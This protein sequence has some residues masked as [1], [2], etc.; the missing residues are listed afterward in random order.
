MTTLLLFPVAAAA[1]LG[2]FFLALSQIGFTC[3]KMSDGIL[4]GVTETIVYLAAALLPLYLVWGFLFERWEAFLW[5]PEEGPA[6][7]VLA[8]LAWCGLIT[9]VTYTAIDL[10]R[11]D[12][13]QARF[14][15]VKV[16]T[17]DVSYSSPQRLPFPWSPRWN[18]IHRLKRVH[19]DIRIPDLPEDLRGLRIGHL[20]DFH[21]G[22]ECHEAF[23]R[24]A[25]DRLM[26]TRPD[27]L[28]ITGDFVN[29]SKYLDDSFKVLEGLTA[30]LGVYVVRG[31]HDYWVGPEKV[32]EHV[33]NAGFTLLD[34]VT[35]PVRKGACEFH[36][37]G[38]ESR[39]NRTSAPFDY[40][41]L[42][43]SSLE[44]V[45]S[46]TPDEFPK[47]VGRKPHLVLSGHTHGGQLCLPFYGPIVVPS[48]YGRKY[49]AGLFREGRTLMVVSRGIGCYPPIRLMCDPE[50]H[51]I[52]FV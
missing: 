35:I 5:S 13:R 45:L 14:E 49:A 50:I 42:N 46:H 33:R 25:V 28:A 27:L 41:P 39:W 51:V 10:V 26:E 19:I 17:E 38:V 12:A 30:P 32:A 23:M 31:N 11:V 48:D 18:G 22:K 8:I 52:E 3:G 29:F 2:I 7:L 24:H 16:R 15:G 1:S 37:S 6:S 40:I 34:N 9:W 44:I 4:K 36:L 43:D 47:L 20:T 21:L